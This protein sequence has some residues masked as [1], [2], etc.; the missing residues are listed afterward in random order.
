M[1]PCNALDREG[2][3]PL[4]RQ[5]CRYGYRLVQVKVPTTSMQQLEAAQ[6]VR[7]DF[8]SRHDGVELLVTL[9]HVQTYGLEFSSP[10]FEHI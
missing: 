4:Q 6:L 10:S 9:H 8:V 7:Y 5:K 3:G 1:K 2:E